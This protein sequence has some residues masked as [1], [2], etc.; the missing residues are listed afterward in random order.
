MHDAVATQADLSPGGLDA[1]TSS[2]HVH[3]DVRV[4]YAM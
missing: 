4:T 3:H 1:S 2:E